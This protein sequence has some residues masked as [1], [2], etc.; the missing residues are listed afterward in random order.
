MSLTWVKSQ[1]QIDIKTSLKAYAVL[2][3]ERIDKVLIGMHGYGDNAENASHLAHAFDMQNTLFLFLEG[4]LKVPMTFDGRHWFDL[5]HNPHQNIEDSSKLVLELFRHLTVDHKIQ[6]EKIYFLGFSQGGGMA[7]YCGLHTKAKI[8][9]IISISGF[10]LNAAK[11]L[12]E[13]SSLNKECPIFLLHGDEDQT[14]FPILFFEAEALL[15]HLKFTNLKTK[16]YKLGH[17]VSN[18]EV[19]DI[20][21]FLLQNEGKN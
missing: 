9:G 11:L 19:Q 3:G 16:L 6:S 8:G 15:K 17:T 4:P 12:A 2:Q 10:I 18:E 13:E 1:H 5:F 21:S 7:L 20:K 14:I